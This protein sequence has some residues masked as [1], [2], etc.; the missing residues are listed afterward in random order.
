MYDEGSAVE[1]EQRDFNGGE[2]WAGEDSVEIQSLSIWPLSQS[3]RHGSK[4]N[5]P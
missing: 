5:S 4:S 2:T 1:P 3:L